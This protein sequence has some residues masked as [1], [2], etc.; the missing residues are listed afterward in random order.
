MPTVFKINGFRF[1]FYSNENDEPMHVHVEK[2]GANGKI[3]LEPDLN[4]AYMHHF[5]SKEVQQIME[6]IAT[7]LL[8]LKQKWNE[9]FSQ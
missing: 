9:Y 6:I 1:Y 3:W 8:T 7:K 2:A 4:I 5:T